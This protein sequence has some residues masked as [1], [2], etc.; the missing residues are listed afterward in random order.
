MRGYIVLI[1]AIGLITL[2]CAGEKCQD[3]KDL[4]CGEDGNTYYNQCYAERENVTVAYKGQ[5]IEDQACTD[6]DGGKD[7]FTAGSVVKNKETYDDECMD[8]STVKEQ[9]CDG[10][11]PKGEALPC[12]TGYECKTG[13]CV[14][15]ECSD[16]EDGQGT[17]VKGTVTAGSQTETDQ[18]SDEDTV[19]EYYCKDGVIEDESIDCGENMVCEDGI[20]VEAQCTET[21]SGKDKNNKGTTEKGDESQT[22][23]CEDKNSVKEYY[24]SDGEI[25]DEILECSSGYECDGGECIKSQCTDSDNGK[26]IFS[27]GIVTYEG[28]E[29]KDNCYSSSH[30][31]EYVCL[32][33]EA[34]VQKTECPSNHEC[35]QGR[36]E[37]SECE[38]EKDDFS[39]SD[40]RYQIESYSS[41]DELTLYE[42]DA[43]EIN[44][45]MILEL[46][47]VSTGEATFSLYE[48]YD[49][50]QQNDELCSEDIEEGN[51]ITDMCGENTGD[52][53]LENVDPSDDYADITLD[54]YY[55]VQ[56]YDEEGYD[57]EYSGDDCP[58]DGPVYESHTAY[59]YPYIDAESSGLN[60]DGEDFKL[61]G[62]NAEIIDIESDSIKFEIDGE[63]YDLEDDEEFE[64][65]D[66]DYVI[67]I[68]F[69]D[70][71]ISRIDIE[72][73]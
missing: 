71:G 19:T 32:D 36:C 10:E 2:G 67:G 61:F 25:A 45:E 23:V 30:V 53:E 50:Y 34:D 4:V 66:M 62:E 60:L 41:S 39:L 33:G 7:T 42:G 24:C 46:D 73:Q 70:G 31:L 5:C 57:A 72:L 12:P 22:D 54:E 21:D 13:R 9:Y 56:Y 20:C 59:F 48:D 65:N 44:D 55:A 1:L 58:D 3:I 16:S 14:E 63:L 11:L 35:V 6:S 47:S 37:R 18:C 28:K 68:T 51:F 64:Y 38:V 49:D 26:D 15:V 17:D 43:V 27:Y 52:I 40:Q 69:S 8:S 29:Y